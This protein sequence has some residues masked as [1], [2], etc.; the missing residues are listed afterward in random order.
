VLFLYTPAGAGGLLEEQQRTHRT[1]ASMSEREVA[2][3]CQ[4]HGALNLVSLGSEPVG[5]KAQ[6]LPPN[7]RAIG[8]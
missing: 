6:R 2:E 4:R 5:R 7:V 1:F 8:R 3:L